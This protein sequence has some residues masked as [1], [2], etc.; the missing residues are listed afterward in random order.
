MLPFPFH[1]IQ[2]FIADDFSL[3]IITS[4][5]KDCWYGAHA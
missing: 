1:F 5:F 4:V 2:L 3:A